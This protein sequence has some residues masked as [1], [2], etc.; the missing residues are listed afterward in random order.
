[1]CKNVRLDIVKEPKGLNTKVLNW[2]L[3]LV[4]QDHNFRKNNQYGSRGMYI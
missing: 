1:M 4:L 3:F 2:N